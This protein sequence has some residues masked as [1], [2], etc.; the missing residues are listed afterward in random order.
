MKAAVLV[1]VGTPPR[2]GD[3][4]EPQTSVGQIIIR[5]HVEDRNSAGPQS[6]YRLPRARS[7]VEQILEF[8]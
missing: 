5:R 6:A 1:A 2:F 4:A 3:F 7:G 8:G